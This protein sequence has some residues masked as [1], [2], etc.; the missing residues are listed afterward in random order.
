MTLT[1]EKTI[2]F[3]GFPPRCPKSQLSDILG[4]NIGHLGGIYLNPPK[5]SDISELLSGWEL[6]DILGNSVGH[7]GE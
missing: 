2:K 1:L 6:S 3:F 7:L 5:M 4:N